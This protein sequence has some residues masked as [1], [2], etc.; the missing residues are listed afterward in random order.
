VGGAT[1]SG[2]EAHALS[3]S[4]A[5]CRL[6]LRYLFPFLLCS[7]RSESFAQIESQH[8]GMQVIL[9]VMHRT[10]PLVIG[11]FHCPNPVASTAPI[12]NNGGRD[13]PVLPEHNA[14]PYASR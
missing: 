6:A 3:S 1:V 10:Q 7:L 8:D 14:G 9:R 5:D 11:K 4:D 2:Q 12:H 13:A